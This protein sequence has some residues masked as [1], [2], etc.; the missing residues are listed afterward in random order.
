MP[1]KIEAYKSIDG[2]VHATL[3][4]ALR[5]EF[6]KMIQSIDDDID[7]NSIERLWAEKDR[8]FNHLSALYSTDGR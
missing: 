7:A 5:H 6:F 1:T 3:Q 8:I 4:G 2:T